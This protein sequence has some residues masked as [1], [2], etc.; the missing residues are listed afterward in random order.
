MPKRAAQF[1]FPEVV[2]TRKNLDWWCERGI[3]FL[4]LAMLVFAPLAFGAVEPWAYLI[5][6]GL[7]AGVFSLWGARLWLGANRRPKILWPPLLWAV[8]AF[9]FYA[10]VRYFTAD[11]K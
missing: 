3:L 2:L 9:T 4:I 6:E 11:K 7:A 5:V 10:V 8:L 1:I